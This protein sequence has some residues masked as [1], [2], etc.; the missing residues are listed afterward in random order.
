M[1][2][3][4][5]CHNVTEEDIRCAVASGARSFEVLRLLTGCSG[6]CGG[7]EQEARQLLN[8]IIA[9]IAYAPPALHLEPRQEEP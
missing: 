8:E 4:C 3:V 9:E 6:G 5:V 2:E 1:F 7:C